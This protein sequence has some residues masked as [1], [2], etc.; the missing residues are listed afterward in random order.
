M[1]ITFFV[2]QLVQNKNNNHTYV[3]TQCG[4]TAPSDEDLAAALEQSS[5]PSDTIVKHF[6][7]PLTNVAVEDTPPIA[8]MVSITWR[9]FSRI[10]EGLQCI[11]ESMRSFY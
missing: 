8:I 5:I 7:I 3:L 9:L 1:H 2:L 11:F 4:N 6:T 10:M